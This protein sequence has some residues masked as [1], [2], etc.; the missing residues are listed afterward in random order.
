MAQPVV[1]ALVCSTLV[2]IHFDT[3]E[4]KFLSPP[5]RNTTQKGAFRSP[6][7]KKGSK[8]RGMTTLPS[9]RNYYSETGKFLPTLQDPRNPPAPEISLFI[10]G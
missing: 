10:L 9:P 7:P 8:E 6:L 2:F 4:H 3:E 1:V 5:P